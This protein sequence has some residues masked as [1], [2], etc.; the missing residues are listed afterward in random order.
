M[1]NFFR[2]SVFLDY[3]ILRP[4]SHI[5][6]N[7]ELL[8]NPILEAY[9]E[10][11]DSLAALLNRLI[12]ELAEVNPP[13]RYHDN[14]DRLAE[15]VIEKLKWPIRKEGPRWLGEEYDV[16][17]QQG[18]FDDVDQREL[19]SA[20]AGRIKAARDRGQLHFDDM[21]ES[22]QRMLAAVLSIIL[23]QRDD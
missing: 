19:M 22:H 15:Y 12:A 20:A 2:N 6:P 8:W 13:P 3:M 17:L 14:E 10:E 11:S 18:S 4:L 1:T 9:E 5:R 21:E 7:W 23:W 16:I